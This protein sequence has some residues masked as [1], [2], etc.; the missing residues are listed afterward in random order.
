MEKV[1]KSAQPK[2]L[3]PKFILGSRIA[4]L[5]L[6]SNLAALIVLIIGAGV[7]NEMRAGFVSIRSAELT[8]Q[9]EIFS[10]LLGENATVGRPRPALV[11]D[12]ARSVLQSLNLPKQV[13]AIVRAKNMRI[14]ADS[15]YLSSAVDVSAL[16]PVREPSIFERI[17][18][19]ITGWVAA[20]YTAIMPDR[21]GIEIR[22]NFIEEFSIAVQGELAVGQRITDRGQRV[23]SISVPIQH[24]SAVV[25]VLT[26]ESGDINEIVRAERAA[27]LPFIGVAFSVAFLTSLLLTFAIARPLRILAESADKV[28]TGTTEKL[29][30]PFLSKRKDEIGGLAKSI[31]SM[32][33]A[34][35]ERILANESFAA[36]VAHELKNP[37][38][39][40][41]SAI[42]TLE[43]VQDDK[44][45]VEKLRKVIEKD[46]QRL[47]RLI[48]DIS[49]ASRLEA[50]ITRAETGAI[51]LGKFLLDIIQTYTEIPG[52]TVRFEDLTYGQ[53]V[54]VIGIEGSLGQVVRN[55][56][57]NA[58]S[59]SPE[60]G[61]VFVNVEKVKMDGGFIARISVKDEG[62][63]IPPDKLEKIFERFYTDRPKGAVYGNNSGLGLSIVAQIVTAHKG[64]VRASNRKDKGACFTVD[65]PVHVEKSNQA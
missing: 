57:D 43:I 41:N 54:H 25:G 55:L 60:K 24:V 33:E 28:K 64:E 50:E 46:V 34:L 32:T 9:A 61:E 58:R 5:I 21:A 40:I 4:R 31:E 22:Q 8:D 20:A 62:P 10:S 19:A 51:N 48:T 30:L 36:D 49:N 11:E 39:S 15:Y 35:F 53:G 59:F 16:P 65:L 52:A 14:V 56:I 13:H 17:G 38:T 7:L 44:T 26:V 47:N 2:W 37:L 1:S 42:Q 27:L 12:N 23:I 3:L 6:L 18:I 63:G 29:E 45:K